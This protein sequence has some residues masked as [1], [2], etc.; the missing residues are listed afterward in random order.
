MSSRYQAQDDLARDRNRLAADRS[1]LSFVRNSLTLIGL[2]LGLEQILAALSAHHGDR[3]IDGW[4]YGLS[5]VY[6]GLGV[7]SL[8]FAIAD[9]QA[10]RARLRSPHYRYQPRHSL[11]AATGLAIF[12]T[13]VLALGW[14]GFD[15]LG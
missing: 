4:A 12:A 9:C 14:L 2:G 13:G 5:L 8:G 10:E 1:L 15:L 6:V 3:N 7:L 11:A